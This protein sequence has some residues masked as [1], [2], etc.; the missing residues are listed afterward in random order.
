MNY[1]FLLRRSVGVRPNLKTNKRY[2]YIFFNLKL[3]NDEV[4]V[5]DDDGIKLMQKNS[6]C[7]S[8]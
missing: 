2:V 4:E 5:I 3:F 8:C 6:L 7:N 1:I